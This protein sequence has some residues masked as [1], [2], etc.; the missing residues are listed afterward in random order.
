MLLREYAIQRWSFIP[1][2]L[3]SVSPL[4]GEMLK[5]KNC[6]F[7]F[8]CSIS[9]LPD[10]GRQWLNLFSFVT[11]HAAAAVWLPKCRC[12]REALDRFGAIA[13]KEREMGVL[14]HSSWTV[15]NAINISAPSCWKIKLPSMTRFIVS[16]ICCDS[17]ISQQYCLLVFTPG[18]VKK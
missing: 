8:A 3:T 5:C 11:N 9:A 17:N 15:L 1:P 2:L 10:F 4:S 6:I 18:L 14:H 13:Q 12:W 7:S 16:N